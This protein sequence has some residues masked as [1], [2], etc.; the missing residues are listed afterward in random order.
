AMIFGMFFIVA[1]L[2][3][4]FDSYKQSVL[5]L[6]TIPLSLIGVFFGLT[7]FMQPLSFPGLI[8]LVAL[9]GIVVRNGIILFDK[10]NL[11][12]REGIPFVESI[13]DAGKTRLEPVVLTSVCTV[14]GMIPLTLSNPTWTSL[15]LSIIFGLSVST[16]FTLLVLP[17]LYF[18]FIRDKTA[19]RRK[20]RIP[21][22]TENAIAE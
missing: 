12:I 5:V 8:G 19:P 10:I 11:N 2:V 22:T 21:S 1:T 13:I 15:G 3:I 9:F 16:V 18:L 17:T 20:T 7:L 6:V 14:L 4:L